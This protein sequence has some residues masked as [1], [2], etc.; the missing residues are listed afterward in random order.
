MG[1]AAFLKGEK[2]SSSVTGSE[3][4]SRDWFIV[5]K[6]LERKINK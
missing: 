2:S 6:L 5:N 3:E 4:L 1:C